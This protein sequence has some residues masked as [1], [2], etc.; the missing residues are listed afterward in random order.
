MENEILALLMA[1]R[2]PVGEKR[3]WMKV[4]PDMTE[5]EKSALKKNLEQEI[6]YE[7]QVSQD[8]MERAC[9]A[10]ERALP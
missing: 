5:E 3:L 10:L 4:L 1:T 2:L 7:I 8:A 6:V 9:E